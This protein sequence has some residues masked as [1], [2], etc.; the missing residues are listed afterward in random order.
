V[1]L[2]FQIVVVLFFLVCIPAHGQE[3][4]KGIPGNKPLNALTIDQWTGQDGLISNNL[5]SVYQ[6]SDNF[7]WITSFN[8]VVRFDGVN[9]KLFDKTN[10]PFL[11]SNGFYKTFE[12]SK[13]NIWFCSQSSG[14]IKYADDSFEQVLP[15]GRNSLSV[16]S[17]A[18]DREGNLWVGTN[19]EGLY[20]YKNSVLSR[21]E[22]EE[23]D[24][25]HIMD[26]AVDNEGK[27]YIATIGD[28]LLIYDNGSIRGSAM[29]D[30]L[31]RNSLNKL[32]MAEDGTI[33][34]GTLDG[35]F[36]I[37]ETGLG[38]IES[39][40]G[41]EINDIFVD[42][43]DNIW[44]AAEQGLFRVNETNGTTDSFTVD[45]GLPSSQVSSL[46]FDHENSLWISTKKSGLMMLKDGYF[47]NLRV[48]EGLSSKN[49]N[50]I[51]EHDNACYI[52]SDDGKINIFK[53]DRITRYP[54]N[55]RGFDLGIRDM[56][57]NDDGEVLIASYRGL[58]K[59][60]GQSE[61]LVDL[62]KYGVRNDIRRILK[63]KDGSIWLGTRSSGVV[64]ISE[65][66]EVQIFDSSNSIKAD[67]ILALEQNSA[68][69]VLVG[70]HSGGLSI[71]RKDGIVENYAIEQ[72]KSG[73]LIFNIHMIDDST[74]WIA[75][76]IGVYKFDT[77]VF[78]KIVLDKKI[79]AETIFDLVF[80]DGFAW[81]SSNIGLI[82]VKIADME[83]FIRDELEN[84]PG[85]LF[86]R[87]DGMAS[88]ECTGATRMTLGS[89]GVLWVPTLGG[90]TRLDPR[91]VIEND[92]VP[93]VFITD[94][95]TDFKSQ[96]TNTGQRV[97]IEP[98]VVRFE[99]RFTSLSYIAPPKVQFRYMLQGLDDDWVEAGN[100]REVVY[101][102]LPK[103]NYTFK[104]IAS[105]ND[106]LWNDQGAKVQFK[107]EPYFYETTLFY[108]GLIVLA[109]LIIWGIIMWRVHNVERVNAELR[110]LNEELDR[111]VYSASHDLRAPLSSVLG[112]VEI[113]RLET[114]IEAKQKCL[115][116]INSSVVKLD[117]FINDIINYSRNQRLELQPELLSISDEVNEAFSEL[118]Y[119]DKENKIEKTVESEEERQF[120]TDGRRLNVILKNIIS[121]AIRYHNLGQSSPFIKVH[122]GYSENRTIISISD[123]GIGI[124]GSHL[125]NIFKMFYRADEASKGSGLGLYIV[126]ETLDKIGGEVNVKSE[127]NVGSTFTISIP[128]LKMPAE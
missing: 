24:L 48:Q 63:G 13:G 62:S 75:T 126:K 8:G 77:H 27:V 53:N 25:S 116:M 115:D 35:L 79:Y 17:V 4:K 12:D 22:M 3:R 29:R 65:S 55:T 89:D 112:L 28:G 56:H 58:L 127:P 73:I 78:S 110:K 44:I 104:V 109:G 61:T 51:V 38:S 10:I 107:V 57:F 100:E 16:R 121:N 34:I 96:H 15:V 72:G 32:F 60:K 54:I 43:F 2:F 23:F 102:N 31:S 114:T 76:N 92:R 124:D 83:A 88:Q 67:Y 42:D 97:P 87:Y 21:V 123:N 47:S 50:I 41:L 30:Q 105:N 64:K 119:L 70:T 128:Q 99:F 36:Y 33:Y 94:F 103:G 111:F 106:G 101:T 6:T 52:G 69:D 11:S 85:K 81:M 40:R 90:A 18:E 82:R 39:L 59:K 45:D 14:I 49:V 113:A 71:I 95:I 7:I 91:G 46:I 122:I 108:I 26:I 37:N 19:N 93:R 1:R 86:D 66:N 74:F 117:G 5:T 125:E 20:V 118:R 68:G 98:G 9:F 120:V 84:V 80:I